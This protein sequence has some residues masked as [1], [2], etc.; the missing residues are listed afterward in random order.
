MMRWIGKVKNRWDAVP[1]TVKVSTSYAICSIFQQCLSFVTLPLFTRILTEEQYGQYTIYSSWS[2][3]LSIFLT[4]NLAYGSFSTAMVKYEKQ[5]DV[6]ISSVQGICLLLSV[7]FLIIYL[8][9]S[10]YWNILFELPTY[11][12]LL[13][14]FEILCNSAIRFWSGKKQ[15]EYKYKGVIGLTVII[16]VCSPVVAFLL[17]CHSEEKG[18]ARIIGYACLTILVGG[19]V[20]IF[21]LIKGKRLYHREFWKYAVTFNVPLLAYYLSQVV[22]NQSD[23]IMISHMS[24]KGKAAFYG[25][26]YNLATVLTFVLNAINNAYVPWFY[27][28]LKDGRQE[29]NKQVSC[30]IALLMAVLLLGIIWFAPEIILVMAGEKYCNAVWVVPPVAMSLLLLFYA[31]LFINVEFFYEEKKLLVGASVGAALVN[32]ALNALCIPIWGYVAAG[33]TTL[34]SYIIFAVANYFAMKRVLQKR[35]LMDNA[36]D[37]RKLIGIFAGFVVCGFVGVALYEHFMIRITAVFFVLL[38]L[39]RFQKRIWEFIGQLRR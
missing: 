32:I 21:N 6:Y 18:Y 23:R 20:Y 39:L 27:E 28:R 8:P 35:K 29:E 19:F 12:V 4:L 17:I 2:G 16:S 36:Y 30:G 25:V 7:L 31:Q 3:I 15:F 9:F 26:A 33:Y 38:I 10:R 24:G 14:V 22:F 11:L 13:M 5:R 1:L 34:V 37:M